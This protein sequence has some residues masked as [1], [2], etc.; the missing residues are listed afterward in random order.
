M[1]IDVCLSVYDLICATAP[2]FALKNYGK[3]T[4]NIRQSVL[5]FLFEPDTIEVTRNTDWADLLI[6]L[7]TTRFLWWFPYIKLR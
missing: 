4:K 5:Q 7:Y 6:P 2:E 3:I 1:H